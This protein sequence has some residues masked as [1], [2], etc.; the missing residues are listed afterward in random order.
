MKFAAK[1]SIDFA[2]CPAGNHVAICNAVVDLG[3]QKGSGMYPDPKHQV[4]VR[5][6]L[7]TEQIKY[8]KDGKEITGPMSIGRSFT[9][10]MSE[11]ANLRKFVESWFGK[12]FPTNEAAADF[13]LSLIVGKKCLVNITHTEKGDKTYANIANA[14]PTPKGMTADY[15][16]H[17]PSLLYDLKKPDPSVY[18]RLPEW[19]QKKL[20]ER[21]NDEKPSAENAKDEYLGGGKPDFDDDIPF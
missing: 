7:P 9:A 1:A 21:L 15:P 17:N 8:T 6:E 13:D 19:L 16:Q 10:S 5:F 2:I 20:N 4:Y 11:K 14:T 12:K 3:L 18:D